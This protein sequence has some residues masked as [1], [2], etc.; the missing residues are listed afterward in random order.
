MGRLSKSGC[1][2]VLDVANGLESL[3]R[4]HIAN[5]DF[6]AAA[7]LYEGLDAPH[8][9]KIELWFRFN[10]TERRLMKNENPNKRRR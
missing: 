6:R 8:E 2:D 9:V 1:L 10:S 5:K 3:M 7:S 4:Y